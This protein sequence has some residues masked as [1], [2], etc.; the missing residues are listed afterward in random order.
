M[1]CIRHVAPPFFTIIWLFCKGKRRIQTIKLTA[2]APWPPLLSVLVLVYH[3]ASSPQGID[4]DSSTN[5]LVRDSIIDAA[6]DA[7]CIKSGES[8][9]SLALNHAPCV[10]YGLHRL[11]YSSSTTFSSVQFSS[12]IGCSGTRPLDGRHRDRGLGSLSSLS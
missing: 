4:I 12:V 10:L 6:D 2:K 9:G 3:N 11:T 8:T 1:T 5:A 7:L